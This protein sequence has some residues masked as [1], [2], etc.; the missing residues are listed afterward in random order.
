[1]RT[2]GM[3]VPIALIVI[4]ATASAE[5]W[6][7]AA[8]L[9]REKSKMDR[10]NVADA[11]CP[12]GPIPYTLDLTNNTFTATNSFGKMFSITVPADGVI[13]VTY[14]RAGKNRAPALG[15][16]VTLEM[17]GNVKSRELEI[18]AADMACYYKLT[19]PSS[20]PLQASLP[21][22]GQMSDADYC[23]A[24]TQKYQTYVVA[25]MSI[26]GDRTPNAVDGNIA[27][28]QCEAGNT[29]SGIPVLERK[30]RDAKVELP[31][32]PRLRSLPA[33]AQMS[34]ADY[35]QA[36]VQ[37]Y[38]TYV[39]ANMSIGSNHTPSAVAGDV[40]ISQCEAGKTASGIPVLEHKLRD[41][42][43]DLPARG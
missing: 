41:A 23:R 29:A 24:L 15:A 26:S 32:L 1:M 9:D 17:T 35:C 36:L 20:L 19:P 6:K 38:K 10:G 37:K 34:D 3:L 27:I 21:A 31:S 22:R 12:Q 4:P 16:Q 11:R 2:M 39:V 43:I 25:N 8:V 33:A 5:T 18:F 13:K 28:A 14:K 7:A 42:K 40:A 30:L